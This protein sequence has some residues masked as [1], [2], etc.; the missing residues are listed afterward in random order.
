M[1]EEQKFD[2][3]KGVISTSFIEKPYF[4]IAFQLEANN[5][6]T[7]MKFF[8]KNKKAK[9]LISS[10]CRIIHEGTTPTG[11]DESARHLRALSRRKCVTK[12][13]FVIKVQLDALRSHRQS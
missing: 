4:P 5:N 3:T 2:P 8:V 7:E 10:S 11:H 6:V 13:G 9:T 12:D 1:S